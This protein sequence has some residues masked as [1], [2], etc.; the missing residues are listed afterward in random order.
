MRMYLDP[1]ILALRVSA[2]LG[3]LPFQVVM[4]IEG[5]KDLLVLDGS[6]KTYQMTARKEYQRS[7]EFRTWMTSEY[8]SIDPNDV[9]AKVRTKIRKIEL[10]IAENGRWVPR[11]FGSWSE[12]AAW[13]GDV[14]EEVQAFTVE[15]P[16]SLYR[17]IKKLGRRRKQAGGRGTIK[18]IVVAAAEEYVERHA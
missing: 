8:A 7:G 4:T 10:L 16:K 5:K 12:M 11:E 18:E 2:K 3:G 9:L 13:L 14:Q 1:E 6:Q 15:F 17:A